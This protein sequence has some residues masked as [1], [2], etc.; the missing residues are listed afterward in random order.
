MS[1]KIDSQ[2]RPTPV[3]DGLTKPF[4]DAAKERRFVIQRCQKCKTYWHP[5]QFQCQTCNARD[6]RFEAVSGRGRIYTHILI[7]DSQ[8]KAFRE[9]L[10]YYVVHI[11]LEEQPWLLY[12]CNMPTTAHKEIKMGAPVEVYFE[13]I[14]GG[15]V[16]P[17]FQIAMSKG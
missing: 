13:E 4:W 16:L 8:L 11:E 1:D 17:E 9:V 10:P 3:P 15:M 2:L 5:P 6:L 7:H 12:Q 14:S